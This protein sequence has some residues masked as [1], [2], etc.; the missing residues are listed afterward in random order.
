MKRTPI[1]TAAL[2]LV[3]LVGCVESTAQQ[4]EHTHDAPHAA[5]TDERRIVEA[6]EDERTCAQECGAEARSGEY[7][8]CLDAGGER[9]A[10][11]SSAR[12]V[13]R[14][15]LESRCTEADVRRDDCTMACR[16]DA[17]AERDGCIEQTGDDESC[18]INSRDRI[19]SCIEDCD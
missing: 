12:L 7:A 11:A 14:E 8:D 10:C 9:Q 18:R 5:Q 19:K 2:L 4:M 17:A 3:I 15:C 6:G 16:T 1:T 13:Y